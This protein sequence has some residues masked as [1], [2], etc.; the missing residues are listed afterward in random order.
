[1]VSWVVVGSFAPIVITV[2]WTSLSFLLI[3]RTKDLSKV[4]IAFITILI[5]S[6]NR[7]PIMAFAETSKIFALLF[8]VI[9]V[10][11]NIRNFTGQQNL[12]FRNFLPFLAFALV[13][14]S[15][16]SDPFIAFQKALSYGLVFFTIPILFLQTLKQNPSFGKDL[17]NF[18]TIILTVGLLSYVINPDFATLAGRYRGL[19]GNPNGMGILLTVAGPLYFLLQRNYP[20]K[21]IDK[22]SEYMFLLVFVISLLFTGSRTSLFAILMFIGFLRIRYLSNSFTLFVFIV[23]VVGYELILTSLPQ[24]ASILGLQEYLRIETL[25][26]GSGRFV[27][28]NFA[29]AQIQEVFFVGGGYGYS[30]IIFKQNFWELSALGHQGN[31]HNSYLTFWLD[32]GLIGIILFATGLFRTIL[33]C[34]RESH[35]AVPVIASILFSANFESWMAASLNPFTSL[36]LICL[37]ILAHPKDSTIAEEE[38]ELVLKPT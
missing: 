38:E 36:F 3:L 20:T 23:V 17:I 14:C 7:V 5:L 11:S 31:A 1:M 13:S 29:W 33:G 21:L 12:I 15:W 37:A 32:T 28:W 8:L 22:P 27:A 6:D 35:Y 19:L 25:D 18:L 10:I 24:I 9:Y 26:E 30:E 16:A 2:S 34:I 4:L